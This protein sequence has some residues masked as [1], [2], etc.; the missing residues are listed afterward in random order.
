MCRSMARRAVLWLWDRF[1]SD[2]LLCCSSIKNHWRKIPSQMYVP[3]SQLV[4]DPE[5][6]FLCTQFTWDWLSTNMNPDPRDYW[7]G[8]F[9]FEH[10][11]MCCL[12]TACCAVYHILYGIIVLLLLS[13]SQRPASLFVRCVS[14]V[15]AKSLT[16]YL[17]YFAVVC[18][19]MSSQY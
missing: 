18:V 1:Y 8:Q 10:R 14:N 3:Y 17:V 9:A 7:G 2:L 15:E 16:R 12:Q 4:N 5:R 19:F 13:L 6:H 11:R